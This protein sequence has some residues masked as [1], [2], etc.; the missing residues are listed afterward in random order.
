MT[1]EE[2]AENLRRIADAAVAVEHSHGIPAEL[3]VGQCIIESQWLSHAPGNNAF[4]L[5]APAG[6][7]VY[8]TV[9][10]DELLTDTQIEK[11]RLAGTPIISISGTYW[12]G[13]RTVRIAD[14]F[15]VFADL[16]DCCEAYAGL[17]TDGK[18]FKA[19]FERF[20]EHRDLVQLLTDMSGAD[21]LPPYFTGAGYVDLWQRIIDQANVQAAIAEARAR[22]PM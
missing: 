6:A 18:Y 3:T 20:Q 11:L 7:A 16:E 9:E 19:R 8:Q 1:T 2:R 17:L 12:G 4:G 15:Q 22:V 13:K 14:R 10:T 5:K 21:G